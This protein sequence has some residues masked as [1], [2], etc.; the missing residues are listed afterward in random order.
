MTAIANTIFTNKNK[1]KDKDKDKDKDK[2]KNY[3]MNIP[4]LFKPAE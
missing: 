2:N 3:R 1:N 4:Y